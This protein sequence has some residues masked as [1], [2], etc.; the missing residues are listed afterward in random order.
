MLLAPQMR[1]GCSRVHKESKQRS[2]VATTKVYSESKLRILMWVLEYSPSTASDMPASKRTDRSRARGV[3]LG[4]RDVSSP[5]SPDLRTSTC[6]MRRKRCCTTGLGV[7]LGLGMSPVGVVSS[8]FKRIT[9]PDLSGCDHRPLI[10]HHPAGKCQP[11]SIHTPL[12][13]LS[14]T[15]HGSVARQVC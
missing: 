13:P 2:P 6:A 14:L 1:R 9:N 3:Q 12:W 15:P 7:R 11:I 5:R 8:N 4:A 10:R